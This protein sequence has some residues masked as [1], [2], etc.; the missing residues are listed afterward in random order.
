MHHTWRVFLLLVYI[1]ISPAVHRVI[2]LKNPASLR[3][4]LGFP[5]WLGDNLMCLQTS[6]KRSH[7]APVP[8]IRD[9]SYSDGRPECPPRVWF[10]PAIDASKFTLRLL[11]DTPGGSKWLKYIL[12]MS[13]HTL[14]TKDSTCFNIFLLSWATTWSPTSYVQC[15]SA[16][17]T[18][19]RSGFSTTCMHWSG[20][21][22]TM[23]C[24][25]QCLLTTTSHE[26]I[27]HI[28]KLFNGM[29]RRWRKWAGTC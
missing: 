19:S 6:H 8:V 10:S 14:F 15:R 17:L 3:V 5:H 25:Y 26:I 29:G 22:S 7:G 16:C 18:P 4:S 28:R 2:I 11:S 12:L 23:Q 1:Q 20:S 13:H 21:T 9:S 27:S 24:S